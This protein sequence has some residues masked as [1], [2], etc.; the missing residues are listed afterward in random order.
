MAVQ[1]ICTNILRAG[2]HK[3]AQVAASKFYSTKQ[4]DPGFG[5]LFDIDGVLIRGKKPIPAAQKAF[6][7]L[8]RPDG[9]F[10]VPTV[11]V[12]NAGNALARTKAEQ[13]SNAMG[14]EITSEQVMMSHSPLRMFPEYHDKCVLLSGQGPVDDIAKKIGF[15]NYVTIDQ[16]RNAFPNLD[17]VDHQRRPKLS[18]S[19]RSDPFPKIDAVILFGE[20]VRW[21]TNLQII[22]DVL[23]TH[24]KLDGP[25]LDNDDEQLPVLA[26]NMDL[27]W[28]SDSHMPRFGHG[29]FLHCLESVYEKLVGRP[30]TYSALMGKPSEVTYIY[31]EQLIKRIA[32]KMGFTAPI[33]NLYAIGDNP[34]ADIYGANLFNKRL[35]QEQEVKQISIEQSSATPATSQ[36][37]WR[38]LHANIR[39]ITTSATDPNSNV[40]PPKPSPFIREVE[41]C[42]SVLV[43]TGVYSPEPGGSKYQIPPVFHGPRDM[44]FD[45][46]LC[47]PTFITH[48]AD[49]AVNK[50]TELENFDLET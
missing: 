16:I 43:C 42:H 3:I 25:A 48:D 2:K 26:C 46:S 23:L 47:V 21:E 49:E 7:N 44:E 8:T 29:T 6:R 19:S 41:S 18:P 39:N 40:I 45:V 15:T 5:L 17:M 38:Q 34:M 37:P 35:K 10:K 20:P 24:G 36:Q 12:T 22:I 9:K 31:A 30:L 28:M 27:L 32:G 50:I 33:K 14:V 11:F 4:Q 1:S 13:L